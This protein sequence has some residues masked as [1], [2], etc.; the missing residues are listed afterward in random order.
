MSW[1]DVIHGART[2]A[3][4][5]A[6]LE[7]YPYISGFGL[8]M[9]LTR[10]GA[11]TPPEISAFGFRNRSAVDVL[12]ATQQLRAPARLMLQAVGLKETRVGS[13]WTHER[14]SPS[15]LGGMLDANPRPVRH[16]LECAAHG[17]H[18]TL[19]QLPSIKI[20]PWHQ[21][22]LIDACPSCPRS[23][24][25][26]F[27]R[28]SKLGRCECGF[29]PFSPT[30]ASVDMWEFP[31]EAANAWAT[32]YLQWADAE[33]EHRWIA[34]DSSSPALA[35]GLAALLSPP[36]LMQ[37]PLLKQRH[38]V[39]IFDRDDDDPEQGTFWGWTQ[40]GGEWPLAFVR[41]PSP[42]YV[43]LVD[44]TR[45]AIEQLPTS[46][47]TPLELVSMYGFQED[48][49]LQDNVVKRPDCFIAPHGVSGESGTWLN[50][51]AI[52]PAALLACR[53]ALDSFQKV[54]TR[55]TPVV[56]RAPLAQQSEAI[57]CVRGRRHLADALT[58]I[59]IRGY[60]QGLQA[61]LR[62]IMGHPA[63]STKKSWFTPI[64]EFDGRDHE[65]IIV[66]LCW[67]AGAPP[68]LRR[69]DDFPQGNAILEPET[70]R[71]RR[72]QAARVK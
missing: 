24:W 70:Q 46:S 34:A 37:T 60:R 54:M 56:D 9:R 26:R 59:I 52:D 44:A 62:S 57:D 3:I 29:D 21:A 51:S 16:C 65:L 23:L 22:P 69:A 58:A 40:L 18:C 72:K 8:L 17:Y 10:L 38:I 64:V 13:H 4:I 15:R 71:K 33:R 27:D 45:Y 20:C 36:A 31:T 50:L 66:R 11:L 68:R 43:H 14:W 32:E 48:H 61:V 12:T 5:G 28:E 53:V 67:V 7:P 39:E 19:F 30:V 2:S 35:E 49:S 1:C 47:R 55:E 41:L 25:S 6:E 42:L 63:V